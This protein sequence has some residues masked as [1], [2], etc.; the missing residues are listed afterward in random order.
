MDTVRRA[1]FAAG[2]QQLQYILFEVCKGHIG[3]RFE[4]QRQ[5]CFCR[6]VLSRHCL[7]PTPSLP[8]FEVW[9][10]QTDFEMARMAEQWAEEA[11][12]ENRDE[13][14]RILYRPY[15]YHCYCTRFESSVTDLTSPRERRIET[16]A[17]GVVWTYVLYRTALTAWQ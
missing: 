8:P 4:A 13:Y 16:N 2:L 17:L 9:R 15:T 14:G 1:H 6:A 3:L 12:H 11:R 5:H 10:T 7:T